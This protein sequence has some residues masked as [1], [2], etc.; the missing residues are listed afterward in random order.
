MATKA[1]TRQH[2]DEDDEHGRL[3]CG[4]GEDEHDAGRQRAQADQAEHQSHAEVPDDLLAPGPLQVGG[5]PLDR[6]D[7]AH[8]L[9]DQHRHHE[10]RGQVPR[11]ADEPHD[12]PSQQ[13]AP[14]GDRAQHHADRGRDQGVA[15]DRLDAGRRDAETVRH[16]RVA[17]AQ[18]DQRRADKRRVAEEDHEV[19]HDVEEQHGGVARRPGRPPRRR[20]RTRTP[21]RG[22]PAPRR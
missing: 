21:R 3:G 15:E 13:A 2:R 1:I 5:A 18:A 6:L 9:D 4:R 16:R 19:L 22:S 10:K 14:L 17:A 11:E 20:R 8:V 7:R 12:E